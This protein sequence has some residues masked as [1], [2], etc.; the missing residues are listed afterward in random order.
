MTKDELENLTIKQL[1]VLARYYDVELKYNLRKA[2]IVDTIWKHL[3]PKKQ[4]FGSVPPE[5]MSVRVRRIY[6]RYMEEE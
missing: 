6:E 4:R 3:H 1:K 5:E 2:E